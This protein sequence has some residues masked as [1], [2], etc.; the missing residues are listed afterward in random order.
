VADRRVEITPADDDLCWLTALLPAAQAM[1]IYHRLSD[2]AV[3]VQ[4]ADDDRTLPQLRADVLCDLLLESECAAGTPCGP[5]DPDAPDADEPDSDGLGTDADDDTSAAYQAADSDRESSAAVA[6]RPEG[7]RWPARQRWP[8]GVSGIR[9]VVVLTV[10]VLSLLGHGDEPADLEGFGPIDIET[11][12][13]LAAQASSFIRVLTHPETGAVLSVG[14]DR[15]RV[16]ADLRTALGIRD[17]TCRF[18]GCRRRAMRCDVD[19]A[20]A[21]ERGGRTDID[22]LEHLCRKHHRLKHELGWTTAH[23]GG[24]VLTWT[25]PVGLSYRSEPARRVWPPKPKPPRPG[26]PDREV[27][28]TA[29]GPPLLGARPTSRPA[30]RTNLRLSDAPLRCDLPSGP[31]VLSRGRRVGACPQMRRRA[32]GQHRCRGTVAAVCGSRPGTRPHGRS[33][34][35]IVHCRRQYGNRYGAHAEGD[36]HVAGRRRGVDPRARR[37]RSGGQRVGFR[38]ARGQGVPR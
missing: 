36:D 34:G 13:E 23:H 6:G 19:H 38:A 11:A 5:L 31:S 8:H 24:G 12:K 25:S 15:Y 26:P 14:R 16:P 37:R 9:P 18:P 33:D 17:E 29:D 7:A 27:A 32:A 22:N 30:T 1:A 10:P 2:I 3:A 28:A 4:G 35:L 21:W 20:R